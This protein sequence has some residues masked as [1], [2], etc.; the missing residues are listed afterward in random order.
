MIMTTLANMLLELLT[1]THIMS[2]RARFKGA[3]NDITQA[4]QATYNRRE[5]M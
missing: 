1:V 2:V 4:E 5:I 3:T